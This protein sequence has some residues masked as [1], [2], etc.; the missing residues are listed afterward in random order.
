MFKR[1]KK[2]KII[3][4]MSVNFQE[5]V[6]FYSTTNS[7][8]S[9]K[10]KHTRCEHDFCDTQPVFANI[11]STK[12]LRCSQHKL[13]NDVDIKNKKCKFNAC[14]RQ[15]TFAPFGSKVAERCNFH[16]LPED[17]D[18]KH[19]KCEYEGCEV[20]PIF[21]DVGTTQG[22]RCNL[23]KCETDV[24][25]VD[26]KCEA[27]GCLKT[28][29]FGPEKG[30]KAVRCSKHKISGDIDV[31]H[32]TCEF[33]GCNTRP[34]YGQPD[35]KKGIRCR[36]HK[37]ETDVNVV[38]KKCEFLNCNTVPYFGPFGLRPMR[39]YQHKL[40]ND[41]DVK[42]KKCEYEHCKNQP[43]FA[44]EGYSAVRCFSHKISGDIDVTRILCKTSNLCGGS[45]VNDKCDGY[46]MFCFINLFPDTSFAKNYKTKERAVV[47]MVIGSFPDF[48]WNIDRRVTDGCSK[49]RPDLLLDL[50]THIII[51]E[52]DENQHVTYDC[53]C[54]N[55][56]MM[57]LSQDVAHR[58]I[59][60]I[61]FNP[62]EYIDQ[63]GINVKSCFKVNKK[64][65]LISLN[66]KMN[67]NWNER[68]NSLKSQINYWINNPT[69]KT[70]EVV[71]LYYDN[72]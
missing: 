58:P 12:A 2:N 67:V 38:D 18:V 56:R 1:N 48:T 25:V 39:C 62:D 24:N 40:Q 68:I 61:R 70:I 19:K 43:R 60:F 66:A 64:N 57:E 26:K 35:T 32:K 30:K 44:E 8:T 5:E 54:E 29:N 33:E 42:N 9:R 65:G 41:V 36:M 3:N 13:P 17:V 51:V 71:Q 20:R 14:K 49:R 34:S 37:Y 63:N 16:K 50:G 27:I 10:R 28:P 4:K 52:I 55:K 22:L 53:S 59:V 69:D 23:H 11:G 31:K 47:D 46:C 72:I 15:P 7:Q 6:E 45:R 21:G